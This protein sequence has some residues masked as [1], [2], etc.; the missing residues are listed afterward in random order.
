M[1]NKII[2]DVHTHQPRGDADGELPAEESARRLLEEMD[3]FGVAI[4]GILG[5]V[6]PGQS[7]EEMRESIRYTHDVAHAASDRLY[8]MVY[9]D[10]SAPAEIIR[11]E[12]DH[13]LQT[14]Y[15]R[16]IKIERDVNCRDK[17]M[18][19]VMEKAIEYNV[20]VLH[21]TWYVNTWSLS[22]SAIAGQVGRS[23]PD[24]IAV[25]AKRFPEARI[26]MAH[27]EGSGIRGVLDV[28]DLPNVWIDTSGSQPFTGTVEFAVETI[29]SK[30]V[31]FGSDLMGRGLESQL[32][33]IY[34][35][36]LAE[37]DLQ[38]I[39]YRNAQE[40]FQIEGDRLS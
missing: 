4:S 14:P 3:L 37:E 24:D 2:I 11:E 27:L 25:L 16:G 9:I 32:G 29:G 5:R 8:G 38:N 23:E 36:N 13:Y 7:V 12:L 17:R 35:A 34:G 39:L 31:L 22:E 40:M 1:N 15:F 10:P 26:L 18:D 20:P 33:R 28:A 21:H 19:V 6:Q 30:R